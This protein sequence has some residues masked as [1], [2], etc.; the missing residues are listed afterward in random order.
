MKRVIINTDN[1]IKPDKCLNCPFVK[2]NQYDPECSL[3]GYIVY[4]EI[5]MDTIHDYCPLKEIEVYDENN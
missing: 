3:L 2:I 1:F 5:M 4:N